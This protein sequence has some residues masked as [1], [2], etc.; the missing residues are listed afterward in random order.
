MA[1]PRYLFVPGSQ[2]PAARAHPLHVSARGLRVPSTDSNSQPVGYTSFLFTAGDPQSISN[3][4]IPKRGRPASSLPSSSSQRKKLDRREENSLRYKLKKQLKAA[5]DAKLSFERAKAALTLSKEAADARDDRLSTLAASLNAR[6]A[7][8]ALRERN[9]SNYET[10][11]A[12]NDVEFQ[13]NRL[14][15][16][17]GAQHHCL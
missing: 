15:L 2:A 6:E 13:E 11:V 1:D 5:G 9:R 4:A 17:R 16:K 3:D 7:A 14:K 8:L 10:A 12:S